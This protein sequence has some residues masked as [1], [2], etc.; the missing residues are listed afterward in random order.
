MELLSLAL[1]PDFQLP[2]IE[3]PYLG[4]RGL[5]GIVMLIHIFF[6]TLFV[7]YAIGSPALQLWGVRT[8]NTWMQRLSHSMARFNVLTFSLGATWAVMFLVV[9][10]GFYPRVTATLF[11]QFFWFF[12]V[13]A[14]ASMI[15]TIYLFYIH[16]Y[17]GQRRNILAGFLAGAFIWLWMAILTG[18][19]SFMVT[20]GG[21]GNQIAQSGVAIGSIGSALDS[22]FNPSFIPLILHRTFG[23]LSWPAFAIAGW[24]GFMYIRSKSAEDKAFYDWAGSMGVVWGTIFLLLQPF[25]GF[26]TALS[27][28]G[29]GYGAGGSGIEGTSGPYDRLVGTGAGEGSFTSDLLVVNLIMVVALFV[30]ANAAM[31]LGAVRHPDRAGRG[32]IQIFGAVAVIAGLYSISP[33]ADWPFLYMR[34]IMMLVMVIATLGALVTYIRGR[35][36]FQYGNPSGRYRAVLLGIGVVA[37][38]LTLSMGWMK[39]NS[40]VPYTIYGQE[41]Y[42]VESA[43]PVTPDQLQQKP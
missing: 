10:V 13:A 16:Y 35:R 34:Y 27:M 14:M 36:W 38:V 5:V 41:Q 43:Q 3:F 7:G 6:A 37:A 30:L 15:L 11:T 20:G 8:G 42:N 40:R 19:D 29:L 33:F 9:I 23:N 24:A 25:I 4:T 21:T 1:Q 17:R 2:S 32:L 18:M 39:S 26:A 12:P 28:K 22:I 31:Y